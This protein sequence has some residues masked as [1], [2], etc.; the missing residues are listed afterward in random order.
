MPA[1]RDFTD[2]EEGYFEYLGAAVP[3]LGDAAAAHVGTVT[4]EG[5]SVP[6]LQLGRHYQQVSAAAIQGPVAVLC[7]LMEGQRLILSHDLSRSFIVQ[8]K[9]L[10]DNGQVLVSVRRARPITSV[11]PIRELLGNSDE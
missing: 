4:L 6:V 2:D 11:G 1:A 9:E 8:A 10:T 7:R 3:S 5:D